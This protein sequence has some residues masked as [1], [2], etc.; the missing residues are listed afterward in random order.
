MKSITSKSYSIKIS[1]KIALVLASLAMSAG[2][3][4]AGLVNIDTLFNTGAGGGFS[5]ANTDSDANWSA[6]GPGSTNDFVIQTLNNPNGGN[7]LLSGAN[8][9][10]SA[11]ISPF[12][13]TR[14]Q[15]GDY[16][17]RTSFNLLNVD[18]SSVNIAGR[19][20]SDNKLTSI[21]LNQDTANQ[22]TISTNFFGAAFSSIATAPDWSDNSAD[23]QFAFTSFLGNYIQ[24]VNTLDFVVNNTTP[25]DT[26]LRVEFTTATA[27][28]I[29]EPASLVL[30]G[31]G[32][33]GLVAARRQ[34][35]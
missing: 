22:A 15:T 7:W 8:N 28:Q 10:T 29:P 2:Q 16:T 17:Y 27:S 20:A 24:G 26:G 31:M 13:D 21:I 18:L 19:W 4:H 35:A 25:G 3:A 12:S 9:A 14:G 30:L 1:G 32:M 5:A 23:Q 33:V 34:K 6:S 11:W